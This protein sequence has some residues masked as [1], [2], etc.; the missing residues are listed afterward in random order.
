M[1]EVVAAV[2]LRRRADETFI[3]HDVTLTQTGDGV[4]TTTVDAEGGDAD[5]PRATISGTVTAIRV[6]DGRNRS[7]APTTRSRRTG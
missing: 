6:G 5:R 7:S 4:R 1:D 3:R 2:T